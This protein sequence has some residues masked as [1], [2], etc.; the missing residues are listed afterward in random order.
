MFDTFS[1]KNTS[2]DDLRKILDYLDSKSIDYSFNGPKE[3][4]E[5][6]ITELSASAQ[7]FLEKKLSRI[8]EG[9]IEMKKEQAKQ[10]IENFIRT[11]VRK[12]LKEEKQKPSD[13]KGAIIKLIYHSVSDGGWV[14]I[15]DKGTFVIDKKQSFI[16]GEIE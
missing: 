11:E 16:G 1:T 5:L 9:N 12:R 14:V 7:N 4:L 10:V 3:I 15:T 6:D 2:R 13:F 8:N